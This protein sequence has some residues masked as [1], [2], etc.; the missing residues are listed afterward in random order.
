LNT[1]LASG[2]RLPVRRSIANGVDWAVFY[3]LMLRHR[4]TPTVWKVLKTSAATDIPLD[5]AT[6]AEKYTQENALRNLA[7]ASTLVRLTR[8]LHQNGIRSIVLKGVGVAVQVYD[9]W[10]RRHAGDIDLFV[11]AHD[12]NRAVSLLKASGFCQMEYDIDPMSKKFN[13]LMQ[14]NNQIAYSDTARHI[15][16]EL[17]WQ[18]FPQQHLLPL[19]FNAVWHDSQS[20]AMANTTFHTLSRHHT[21]LHACCHGAKHLWNR[22]FWLYDVALCINRFSDTDWRVLKALVKR[23]RAQ[24]FIAQALYL[25]RIFFD[26]Q[27]PPAGYQLMSAGKD[28]NR[29][30]YR[31]MRLMF[32]FDADPCNPFS[33]QHL[34][35]IQQ[36][37]ALRNNDTERFFFL[38][39][40]LA[41]N[42]RDFDAIALPDAAAFLYYPLKPMIWIYRKMIGNHSDDIVS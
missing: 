12:L 3:Q 35:E 34:M 36:N 17:H 6:L 40:Y 23:L 11:D 30:L 39:R 28:R 18:L 8:V 25:V 16:I 41:P 13:L 20:I 21:L 37:L 7:L 9:E 32:E 14:W 22:L 1:A 31:V 10:V 24:Q 38:Y 15:D 4:V 26:V 33:I 42:L 5:F 29:M 27:L 2:Q 19:T